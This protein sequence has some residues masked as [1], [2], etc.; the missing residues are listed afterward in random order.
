MKILITGGYGQLG[1]DVMI[2][3]S[4]RGHVTLSPSHKELDITDEIAV[5][6][7]FDANLPEA[8]IHCAAYTAVDN[9][10]TNQSECRKVNVDGTRYITD[11]CTKYDIPELFISTDY[12]FNGEGSNPWNTEDPVNPINVY[13]KSKSDA[14]KIVKT[15]PKHF[16]V[17]I[18]WVFGINGNNFVKTMLTL[19]ERLKTLNVVT[20]QIGS[21]TYTCDLAPLLCNM[22][23]SNKYG[24]Y[25]AHNEGYCSWYDFAKQIFESS[26]ISVDVSPIT[27]DKYPSI[28]KRPLNSRLSS[29]SLTK[30]GFKLLPEWKDAVDRFII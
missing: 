10:E 13:G 6:D 7:F 29:D 2:E 26:K 20:D 5:K 15:N 16:I 24:I 4:E 17:R 3:A 21:P 11:Q 1:H 14:E 30:A 19:S 9:A 25:L 22:I 28:A 27:S 12:V 8:V 23:E 18:S